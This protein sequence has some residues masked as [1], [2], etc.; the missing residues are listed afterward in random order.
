MQVSELPF[1][2]EG[3]AK[4]LNLTPQEL[5]LA[6]KLAKEEMNNTE[7]YETVDLMYADIMSDVNTFKSK[8]IVPLEEVKFVTIPESNSQS[9]TERIYLLNYWIL[10]FNYFINKFKLDMQEKSLKYTYSSQHFLDTLVS[11]ED[12]YNFAYSKMNQELC[13]LF[14]AYSKLNF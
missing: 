10:A 7:K 14:E 1:D 4:A 12:K 6:L 13:K 9:L 5:E 11:I 3:C 8:Y 2:L